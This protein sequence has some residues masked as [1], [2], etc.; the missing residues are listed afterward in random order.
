MVGN[1]KVS[2]VSAKVMGLTLLFDTP[3]FLVQTHKI[4]I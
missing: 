3:I 1:Y 2:L 4:Q